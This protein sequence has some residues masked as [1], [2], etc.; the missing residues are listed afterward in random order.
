MMQPTGIVSGRPGPNS[1]QLE[2]AALRCL[3]RRCSCLNREGL[4]SCEV[5]LGG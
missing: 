2:A 1:L 4:R 3:V 5:T